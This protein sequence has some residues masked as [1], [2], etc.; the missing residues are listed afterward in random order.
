VTIALRINVAGLL[1]E[2]AGAAREYPLSVPTAEVADVLEDARPAAPL[3]GT[4]RLMRTQQSVFV[5]GHVRTRVALDCSRCLEETQ[6]PLEI[7]V[8]AEYFP[9][10]D[11]NT[12]QTL[13]M[14]DDDLAFTIDQNHELDLSEAV[15]QGLLLEMPMHAICNEACKGICPSCGADLNLGPCIC[16]PEETDERLAPLRALLDGHQAA[17]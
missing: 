6:V 16:R 17:S 4:V 14:P 9:E 5:R 13:T 10:I 12:G 7:D 11:V 2:T 1:K 8:E 15:R 3:E